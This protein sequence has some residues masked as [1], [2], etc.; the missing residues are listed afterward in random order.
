[1]N[2]K[3]IKL[4][5][6]ISGRG[7]NLQALID[8]IRDGRLKATIEVV[9]SDNFK[10]NG[11]NIA[12]RYGIPVISLDRTGFNSRRGFEEKILKIL[13]GYKPDLIVLAGFMRILS[14]YFIGEFRGRIINIHPS[15]L[16]SFPGLAAQ[17]QALD[18][19]VKY[20]GATVHFVDTGVDTGPII[21]QRTVK[22]KDSDSVESLSKRILKV[23]HR[24]LSKAIELIRKDKIKVSGRRVELS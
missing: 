24:I 14:R 17:K 23:E 1:M 16:P 15:L 12:L 9:I 22:V 11:V 20:S 19:G 3:K 4:A 7:S 2:R 5:V 18:Y 6:F 10:A 13:E 21:I 8:N